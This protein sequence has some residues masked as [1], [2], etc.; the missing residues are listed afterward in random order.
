MAKSGE[1]PAMARLVAR[2]ITVNKLM[3]NDTDDGQDE[4]QEKPKEHI[5]PYVSMKF[6]GMRERLRRVNYI[7][8]AITPKCAV[9]FER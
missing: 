2:T 7:A 6:R 9:D 8:C 5:D 3:S 4:E 1:A